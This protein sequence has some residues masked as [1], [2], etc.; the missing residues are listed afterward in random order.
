M[1]LEETGLRRVEAGV[2]GGHDDIDGRDQAHTGGRSDLVLGDLLPNLLEV[3]LSEHNAD[4]AD[5]QR[6]QRVPRFIAGPLAEHADGTL[7][8]SVLPHEDDRVRPQAAADV[9]HLLRADIVGG[10][11]KRLAVLLQ[12]LVHAL[13]VN[14]LLLSLSALE[15]HGVMVRVS[16][17]KLRMLTK[18]PSR[19]EQD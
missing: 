17:D 4:V 14:L 19:R 5:E 18:N 2:T 16:K 9:L 1:H 13:V 12:Q 15:T 11:D 7:Q 3:S 8:E 10:A 6:E